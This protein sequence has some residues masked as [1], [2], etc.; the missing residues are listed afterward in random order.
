LAS[1]LIARSS[2]GEVDW[3]AADAEGT[4]YVEYSS[5]SVWIETDGVPPNNYTLSVMDEDGDPLESVEV[6]EDDD[7]YEVFRQLFSVAKDWALRSE[8]VEEALDE[9]LAEI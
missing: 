5:S 9:L 3:S 4:F 2:K 7:G 1:K 6:E 8:E